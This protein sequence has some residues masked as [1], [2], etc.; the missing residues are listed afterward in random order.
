MKKAKPQSGPARI[1]QVVRAEG[2]ATALRAFVGLDENGVLWGYEREPRSD[3]GY[4]ASYWKTRL[5]CDTRL[6]K[7]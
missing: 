5:L 2:S 7:R 1:V 4:D 6:A 3:S